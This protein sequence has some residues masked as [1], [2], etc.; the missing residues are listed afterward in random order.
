MNR[1]V[2][3]L[4]CNDSDTS[5]IGGELGNDIVGRNSHIPSHDIGDE[6]GIG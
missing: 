6:L 3:V 2:K 4:T 1:D 5:F